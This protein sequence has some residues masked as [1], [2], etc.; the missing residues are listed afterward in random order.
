MTANNFGSMSGMLFT[1][2]K[3][4]YFIVSIKLL[5]CYVFIRSFDY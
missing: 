1:E 2:D 4:I 5:F 3:L